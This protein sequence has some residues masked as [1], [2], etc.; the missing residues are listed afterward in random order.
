[1]S[2]LS[3]SNDTGGFLGFCETSLIGRDGSITTNCMVKVW[4][5][6]LLNIL[7]ITVSFACNSETTVRNAKVESTI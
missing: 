1:M 3:V 6:R 4:K 7:E 2:G 5:I